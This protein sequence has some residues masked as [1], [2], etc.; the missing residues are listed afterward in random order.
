MTEIVLQDIA[1]P[2]TE[3]DNATNVFFTANNECSTALT[4]F[5][6]GNYSAIVNLNDGNCP[7]L[8]NDYVTACS[9]DFGDKV[10]MM[11][12]LLFTPDDTYLH[13]S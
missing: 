4:S 9:D 13:N 8:F 2:P 6:Q 7:M 5:L 1:V 10:N 3:C 12:R 11:P